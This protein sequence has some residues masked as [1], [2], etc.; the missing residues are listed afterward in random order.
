MSKV[1]PDQHLI[2]AQKPGLQTN[3]FIQTTL[4]PGIW[5]FQRYQYDIGDTSLSL[6][7]FFG[8]QKDSFPS[9]KMDFLEGTVHCCCLLQRGQ[10][11]GR[12]F[13]VACTLP[14]HWSFSASSVAGTIFAGMMWGLSAS[15]V[16]CASVPDLHVQGVS[17]ARCERLSER[18]W[19]SKKFSSRLILMAVCPTARREASHADLSLFSGK[20]MTCKNWCPRVSNAS[21]LFLPSAVLLQWMVPALQQ[22]PDYLKRSYF[23]RSELSF[24]KVNLKT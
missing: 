13:Q 20:N 21:F 22:C 17:L 18:R 1:T 6:A 24:L 23:Q 14:S 12:S 7:L 16:N 19:Y 15:D 5:P 3:L 2:P 4:L 9:V 11:D 8:V 10:K